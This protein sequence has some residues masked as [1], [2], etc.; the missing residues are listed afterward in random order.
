MACLS[1]NNE[2]LVAL[3]INNNLV[4][5]NLT[6]KKSVLQYANNLSSDDK[7]SNDANFVQHCFSRDGKYLAAITGDKKVLQWNLDNIAL[8]PNVFLLPK[9]PTCLC[10]CQTQEMILAGD[11]AGDVHKCQL[12][13]ENND[14]KVELVLGHLSMVLDLSMTNDDAFLISADRD[15]KIRVSCFPNAYNI[16][17]YCFG[18]EKLV[19]TISVVSDDLLVSGSGD[20]V[21]RLWDFKTGKEL[22]CFAMRQVDP[23]MKVIS[24]ISHWDNTLAVMGEGSKVVHFF[25]FHNTGGVQLQHVVS[26]TMEENIYDICFQKGQLLVLVCHS[27]HN[28][29]LLRR[30]EEATIQKHYLTLGEEEE[31]SGVFNTASLT[32]LNVSRTYTDLLKPDSKVR[33]DVRI[34]PEATINIGGPWD[35]SDAPCDELPALS[36]EVG[37]VVRSSI[38]GGTCLTGKT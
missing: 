23:D 32:A 31:A 6:T 24:K 34:T 8:E 18:H 35:D 3:S 17:G 10:F 28:V 12:G 29:V 16:H 13:R 25:T 26:F 15:E 33:T 9:R 14:P 38:V 2:D 5:H 20:K 21:V 7:D 27:L 30:E 1:C 11:K 36:E 4:V 37:D 19:S 22:S